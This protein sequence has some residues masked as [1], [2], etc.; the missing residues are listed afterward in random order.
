MYVMPQAPTPK[1]SI[2][3]ASWWDASGIVASRLSNGLAPL[4]GAEQAQQVGGMLGAFAHSLL[5]TSA[6][7]REESEAEPEP[8]GLST[9]RGQMA[10]LLSEARKL[11][12]GPGAVLPI[13]RV[14]VGGFSQGAMTALDA[15]LQ[16]E[17]TEQVGGVIFLSGAPVVTAQWRQRLRD[18]RADAKRSVSPRLGGSRG[19]GGSGGGGGG[20]ERRGASAR[21]LRVLVAHGTKDALLPVSG[22]QRVETLLREGGACVQGVRHPGKHEIGGPAVLRAI[23]EFARATIEQDATSSSCSSSYERSDLEKR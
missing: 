10:M 16:A 6:L 5:G 4:L 9:C 3:G 19:S 1:G 14:L 18:A 12:G 20:L 22:A 7:E 21:P 13:E 23:A 15:A 8:Q 17:R 11:A 2:F